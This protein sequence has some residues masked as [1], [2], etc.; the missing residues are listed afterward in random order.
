RYE[1]AN[2][3]AADLTRYLSDEPLSVGPPS[4]G[5]RLRKFARRNRRALALAMLLAVATLVA[6]GAVAASVGWI[7][8]DRATRRAAVEQQAAL[9]FDE[10][11]GWIEQENWQKAKQA[12]QRGAGIL[13]GGGREGIRD[14]M[15]RQ[16][17]HV[18]M[19]LRLEEIDYLA[20]EL[21]RN[22][23]EWDVLHDGYARAFVDFGVDVVSLPVEEAAARLRSEGRITAPL[24]RALDTWASLVSPKT[25]ECKPKLR[26]V[27]GLIDDDHWRRRV[28]EAL[29]RRDG[30][31]LA[32][33][34]GSPDLDRQSRDN[35]AFLEFSLD[36]MCRPDLALA[37]RR[38]L[39]RNHPGNFM[40]TYWLAH[41]LFWSSPSDPAEVV[42]FARAAVALRPR[43][44]A[45][46][47]LLA[48]ALQRAGKLDESLHHHD[49]A[50]EL[51]PENPYAYHDRGWTLH[52][53]GRYE[54][55][56][57]S[58]RKAIDLWD[59]DHFAYGNMARS[60]KALNRKPES[61]A[62]SR[63]A[64]EFHPD[65][66]QVLFETAN[67]L[68]DERRLDE[69]I[70]VLNE[71]IARN[72][73]SAEAYHILG[74]T[75]SSQRKFDE[76]IANYTKA[77]ELEPKNGWAHLSL[78]LTRTAQGQ[79]AE[80]DAHY[81]RAIELDPTIPHFHFYLGWNWHLRGDDAEAVLCFRAA[82]RLARNPAVPFHSNLNRLFNER[83]RRLANDPNAEARRPRLAVELAEEAVRLN[84]AIGAN[85]N[86]LGVA[87]YRSGDWKSAVQ[88]LNTSME[89]LAGFDEGSNLFFLALATWQMGNQGE[90]R[91]YYDR[92]VAWTDANRPRDPDL[93]RFRA[94]ASELLRVGGQGKPELAPA[95]RVE[96]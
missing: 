86:T 87:H 55:A 69:A 65:P 52:L 79:T 54:E 95:S 94:E 40:A 74:R 64:A 96:R 30:E 19:M 42:S 27:A 31:S 53:M 85:W 78:G 14:R 68:R 75:L 38:L 76:A 18:S 45:A 29:E 51:A 6:L 8:H 61:L 70:D 20:M 39:Q 1:T 60:L 57:A 48:I 89:R 11:E 92:A 83:A 34:A 4:A 13:A 21:Q 58:N 9:A 24:V 49:K 56:V 22:W 35:L 41:R 63:K 10:A 71:I 72:P 25:R 82:T 80:A 77:I 66:L 2:G 67:S 37:V 59:R 17:R 23:H 26:A 43:A 46:Q 3:F 16:D 36:D 88:A 44:A 7:M 50:I 90:A 32:E 28:R 12:I 33:L 47:L 81:R 84:P 62:A 73:N 5:Y 93:I 15:S 91:K